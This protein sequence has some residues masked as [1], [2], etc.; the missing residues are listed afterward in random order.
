MQAWFLLE[1][2][3]NVKT[4]VVFVNH[5]SIRRESSSSHCVFA[6]DVILNLTLQLNFYINQYNKSLQYLICITT[7]EL[8]IMSLALSSRHGIG[9]NSRNKWVGMAKLGEKYCQ[10]FFRQYFRSDLRAVHTVDL[11]PHPM[12]QP[13]NQV[14]NIKHICLYLHLNTFSISQSD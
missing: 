12:L 2:D 5:V 14:Q 3:Q 11:F 6:R 10:I 1:L 9:W 8:W 13:S 7:R 4:T